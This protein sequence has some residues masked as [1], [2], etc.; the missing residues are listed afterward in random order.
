MLEI[1]ET[2]SR[3]PRIF[4]EIKLDTIS[5]IYTIKDVYITAPKKNVTSL[6][7]ALTRIQLFINNLKNNFPNV[8]EKD[9]YASNALKLLYYREVIKHKTLNQ[10]DIEEMFKAIKFFQ[11]KNDIGTKIFNLIQFGDT[12]IGKS[13]SKK[14]FQA[15]FNNDILSINGYEIAENTNK[16][17]NHMFAE[18]PLQINNS[19]SNI[20]ALARK[21]PKSNSEVMTSIKSDLNNLNED[22]QTWLKSMEDYISKLKKYGLE[23]NQDEKIL[24]KLVSIR[25]KLPRNIEIKKK[26]LLDCLEMIEL[27]AKIN[28]VQKSKPEQ[29][30]EEK[31]LN[32]LNQNKNLLPELTSNN[33]ETLYQ[34]SEDPTTLYNSKYEK[35]PQYLKNIFEDKSKKSSTQPGS[36]VSG[37]F[38]FLNISSVNQTEKG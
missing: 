13:K 4:E 1:S 3:G 19:S 35:L 6:F 24:E 10:Q 27:E 30:L 32:D 37:I 31:E 14:L 9:S 16:I 36:T 34:E 38:S 28:K 22:P 21:N 29:N 26:D 8:S 11:D 25:K 23:L 2:L 5:G 18:Q 7:N 17:R 33:N 15:M 20:L 12:K